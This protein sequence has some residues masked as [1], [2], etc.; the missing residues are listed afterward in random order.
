LWGLSTEATA[1]VGVIGFRLAH[2]SRLAEV[3]S[4]EL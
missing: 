3:G 4:Q 1:K 2:R